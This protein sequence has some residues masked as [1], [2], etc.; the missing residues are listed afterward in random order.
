MR[1]HLDRPRRAGAIGRAPSGRA[2]RRLKEPGTGTSLA[3]RTPSA[4]PGP[5]RACSVSGRAGVV[6]AG[7]IRRPGRLMSASCSFSAVEMA[8][9]RGHAA[10]SGA[11]HSRHRLIRGPCVTAAVPFCRV[12]RHQLGRALA[13]PARRVRLEACRSAVP[14]IGEGTCRHGQSSAPMPQGA[15]IQRREP[16]MTT[17]TRESLSTRLAA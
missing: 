10:A 17:R 11:R 9:R 8:P 3:G 15:S 14:H 5:R 1:L 2:A 7:M 16:E 12:S 6:S 13:P 4:T